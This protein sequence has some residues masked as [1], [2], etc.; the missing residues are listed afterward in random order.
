MHGIF[1]VKHSFSRGFLNM[2]PW[3]TVR[4]PKRRKTRGKYNDASRMRSLLT[5]KPV[6]IFVT[7]WQFLSRAEISRV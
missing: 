7:E 1:L 4:N 3:N 6:L 5:E 2:C